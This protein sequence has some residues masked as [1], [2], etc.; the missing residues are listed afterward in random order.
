MPNRYG[1]NFY[2][3]EHD[4]TAGVYFISTD[5]YTAEKEAKQL[6]KEG[7]VRG[8]IFFIEEKDY[9]YYVPVAQFLAEEVFEYSFSIYRDSEKKLLFREAFEGSARRIVERAGQGHSYK[10]EPLA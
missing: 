5:F 6:N 3:Q 2:N 9:P 1:I 8:E 4:L 10:K 7:W